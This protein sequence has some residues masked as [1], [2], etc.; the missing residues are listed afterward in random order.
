MSIYIDPCQ[1]AMRLKGLA[2]PGFVDLFNVFGKKRK[3]LI[4]KQQYLSVD[5]QSCD[6]KYLR[7]STS[8][9]AR[10][11]AWGGPYR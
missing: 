4:N 2:P 11:E 8:G 10:R 6:L 7:R 1:D 3:R 9:A 5:Q